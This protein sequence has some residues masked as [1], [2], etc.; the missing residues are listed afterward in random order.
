MTEQRRKFYRLP[1]EHVLEF[2]EYDFSKEKKP[3]NI[4]KLK[5]V[6]GGGVL[7]ETDRSVPIGSFIKVKMKIPG[8]EKFR[9]EFI[10]PDW[11]SETEPLVTLGSVVR[12]EEIEPDRRYDIGIV[13]QCIDEDHR[14]ALMNYIDDLKR[15]EED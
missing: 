15:E 13:F 5:N 11:T 10:K 14:N 8:W 6:S 7:F 2:T 4:S 3:F 9:T 1:L 12:V